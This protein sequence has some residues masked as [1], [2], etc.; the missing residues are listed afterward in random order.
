MATNPTV[1]LYIDT[2]SAATLETLKYIWANSD[3]IE[4]MGWRFKIIK[5]KGKMTAETKQKLAD[6]G[7]VKWPTMSIEG[8]I[9]S[10]K[11]EI[12]KFIEINKERFSQYLKETT[13]EEKK[14]APRRPGN[15]RMAA[16]MGS[17]YEGGDVRESDFWMREMS[18]DAIRNDSSGNESAYGEGF[19]DA[20]INGRMRDFEKRKSRQ[21]GMDRIK[22]N[23]D[24]YEKGM[25]RVGGQRQQEPVYSD[26]AVPRKSHARNDIA[27]TKVEY[28]DNFDE[29][30][31]DYYNSE[32][33]IEG[34][35][36]EDFE[37]K[38]LEQGSG[39]FS[40]DFVN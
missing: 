2:K 19:G 31:Y 17:L 26:D 25:E 16:T 33:T 28:D 1:E 27:P 3:V 9:K 38:Y 22:K 24:A 37:Q 39:G 13:E 34:R 36:L 11:D 30:E 21:I 18:E 23:I 8:R 29:T 14:N 10:G 4:D 15:N 7:I 12:K 6:K 40:N 32:M 35:K 5:Y 20:D